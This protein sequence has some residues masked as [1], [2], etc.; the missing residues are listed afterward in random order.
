[1]GGIW[2]TKSPNGIS[3]APFRPVRPARLADPVGDHAEEAQ[4]HSDEDDEVR[5]VLS[6]AEAAVDGGPS[7]RVLRQ[8]EDEAEGD[9]ASA[10]LR[11]GGDGLPVA[12]RVWLEHRMVPRASLSLT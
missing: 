11:Q 5:R 7:E 6:E 10:Q 2:L 4:D 12:S 3:I 9:R 1:M 8:V